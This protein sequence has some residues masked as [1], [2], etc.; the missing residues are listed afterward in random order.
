MLFLQY[1]LPSGDRQH[2]LAPDGRAVY[3]LLRR[4]PDPDPDGGID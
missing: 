1:A 2:A 3:H 4:A